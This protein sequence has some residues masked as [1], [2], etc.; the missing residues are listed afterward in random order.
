MAILDNFRVLISLNSTAR[1]D[2]LKFGAPLCTSAE[3][4]TMG[5][6]S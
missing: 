2:L 3:T 5:I 1:N 6:G 4:N